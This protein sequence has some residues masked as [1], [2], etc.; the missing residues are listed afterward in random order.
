MLCQL[1]LGREG[2]VSGAEPQPMYESLESWVGN[3]TLF[4]ATELFEAVWCV[5]LAN[6][7]AKE[8]SGIRP[9]LNVAFLL[10]MAPKSSWFL[11]PDL[12]EE[13][14]LQ[15]FCPRFLIQLGLCRQTGLH[16]SCI[17]G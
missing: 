14:E 8:A 5:T 12:C 11:I 10:C 6:R 7:F 1:G 3:T 9:L 2:A 16:G 17:L 15:V 4:S 13:L